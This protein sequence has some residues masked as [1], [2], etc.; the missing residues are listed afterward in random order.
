MYEQQSSGRA[1]QRGKRAP[2]GS[3]RGALIEAAHRVLRR[4]GAAGLTVRAVATEAGVAPMGVYNHFD[5]KAG[6]LSAVVTDGFVHL[7]E[8]IASADEDD[9]LDRLRTT[10][11]RY[12]QLA[13]DSPNLYGLMFA[14][15]V[16]PDV[17]I[18]YAALSALTDVVVFGQRAGA[19]RDIDSFE[20]TIAIW[21]AVHGAVSLEIDAPAH[22][23]VRDWGRIYEQTLD[24]ISR[25][26]AA[27]G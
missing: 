19:I 14:S 6:L 13:I 4:D 27:T 20:L 7:R 17:E 2:A 25:G 16:V 10:G 9:P 11:I 26:V 12:R 3:V 24:M 22:D 1:E 15:D 23:N 5:G 18:A 8:A 21:S